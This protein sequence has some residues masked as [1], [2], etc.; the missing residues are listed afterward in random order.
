MD[1]ERT[2]GNA[3]PDE[4]IELFVEL[5]INMSEESVFEAVN[6]LNDR[7][8]DALRDALEEREGE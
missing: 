4:C 5:I 7:E 1:I 8:A 6:Q 2:V 3:T